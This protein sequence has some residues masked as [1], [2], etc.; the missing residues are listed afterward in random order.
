M[1]LN[2]KEKKYS[3]AGILTIEN[4]NVYVYHSIGGEENKSNKL[5]KDLLSTFC[6][7]ATV[8]S[9]GIY[10]PLLSLKERRAIDS[11][12]DNYFKSAM[13]FDTDF[14]LQNDDRMYCTEF[15]YKIFE[16][17][18]PNYFSF[19]R[20]SGKDYIACDDLYINRNCSLIYS[21][22]Y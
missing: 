19:S 7:P 16:K 12:A 4:R 5:R 14:D 22:H 9:F 21:Y 15:V 18:H 2:Q 13:E 17:V 10:K 3:H 11:I 20:F 8:Y 1:G 6:N